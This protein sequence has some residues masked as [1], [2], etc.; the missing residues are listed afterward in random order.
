MIEKFT[1]KHYHGDDRPIIKGNS[2]DGL[3]IGEDREESEEFIIFVNNI[4][5]KNKQ[6]KERVVSLEEAEHK[7]NC[8][9]GFYL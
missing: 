8:L 2:F 5:N 7:L 9:E 6:L 3:E 4:I 1:V